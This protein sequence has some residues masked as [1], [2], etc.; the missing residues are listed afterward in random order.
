MAVKGLKVREKFSKEPTRRK[1]T[2]HWRVVGL[3]LREGM[4]RGIHGD[5]SG[6]H[7]R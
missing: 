6:S 7:V 3:Y 1:L 2:L 5:N 4:W